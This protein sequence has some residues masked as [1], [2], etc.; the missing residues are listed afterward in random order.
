MTNATSTRGLDVDRAQKEPS[1]GERGWGF[2]F[3][4]S[5]SHFLSGYHIAGQSVQLRKE[6]RM[7]VQLVTVVLGYGVREMQGSRQLILPPGASSVF[8]P[9]EWGEGMDLWLL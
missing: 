5:L 7:V 9:V 3:L 6:S 2:S 4:V 8:P 1:S